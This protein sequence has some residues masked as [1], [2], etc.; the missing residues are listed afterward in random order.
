M[1]LP[2]FLIIGQ[3]KAGTT[4]L[5]AYLRQHPQIFMPALKE[6]RFFCARVDDPTRPTWN[7]K[8][9]PATLAEYEELFAVAT[10][11]TIAIGEASPEYLHNENAAPQIKRYLGDVKLIASL[12]RPSDRVYSNYLMRRRMGREHRD[13]A[14]AFRDDY[15]GAGAV[16]ESTFEELKVYY[17]LFGSE[18]IKVIRF[19]GLARDPV[20][21][22][23]D[24][25]SF[26]NVDKFEPNTTE[27][28]NEGG[29]WKSESLGKLSTS[30][31]ANRVLMDRLKRILP[32]RAWKMLKG[33]HSANLAKPPAL[34][35][36]LRADV[37]RLFGEDTR[38]VQ[39]LIRLDLSDWIPRD[40]RG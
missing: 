25:F 14:T 33:L 29:L 10:P 18:L 39:D 3:M 5:H 7:R 22:V 12:R 11:Q 21:T 2:N 16:R 40:R 4:S 13:F 28:F 34:S 26:L 9:L 23:Q 37:D 20:A 8:G 6:T 35:D 17:D 15:L 32:K 27:R 30:I 24:L 36:E 38:R 31:R 1:T 19:D